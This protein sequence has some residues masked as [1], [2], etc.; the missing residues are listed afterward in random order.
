MDPNILH[1]ISYGMYI[2]SSFRGG[3]MNG[4]IVNAVIQIT[5]Q[6]VT[7]AV[8][9]NKQNLTREFI[10]ASSRIGLSIL[11]EDTPLA[12]IGKFGFHS[13][14]QEDK[15]KGLRYQ[16]LDSGC[17]VVLD[18]AIG[19]L[20]LVVRRSCDCG[21]HMLYLGEMTE[22]KVLKM[23]RPMTYEYYHQVKR[24]TTPESAPTFIKEEAMPKG[25]AALKRYRCVVC[26]YVYHPEIGDPDGGVQPGTPFEKIPDAWVCPV[27]GADKSRFVA[28]E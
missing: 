6:P 19:Y 25:A 13:G 24:G 10:D 4:Q 9:V 18:Y 5:S 27:C 7:I 28:E 26:N 3:A 11:G 16:V 22:S 1:N 20:E 21:T 23:G 14:R 12:F 2:A 15:F 8:S 17:P